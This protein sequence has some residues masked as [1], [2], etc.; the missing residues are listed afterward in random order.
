MLINFIKHKNIDFRKYDECV[1]SS[2]YGNAYSLATYLDL[3]SPNWN[4]LQAENYKFVMPLPY[5]SKF[6][7]HYNIQPLFCQQLGIFSK[8][9]ITEQIFNKFINAIPQKYNAL[10]LNSGNVFTNYN[11]KLLCNYRLKLN[12]DFELLQKN[13]STNCRRNYKKS[14]KYSQQIVENINVETFL[15]FLLEQK[16]IYYYHHFNLI[17][18]IVNSKKLKDSLFISGVKTDTGIIAAALFLK[19]HT[20]FYYLI[21]VSDDEA[22]QKQSM[23]FLLMNI[24]KKNANTDIILDFEGSSIRNLQR[25]YLGF[26]AE[27]QEFPFIEINKFSTI[28]KLL[29]AKRQNH[30][31]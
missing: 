8:E 9:K 29:I 20:T 2:I 26:G 27:L 23:T 22:K 1:N 10:Q 16:P 30:N 11:Q 13:F 4:L 14:L 17:R 21:P 7:I 12:S 19:W 28:A 15:N 3:V 31:K 6:G 5:K 25:F 18:D 24:I